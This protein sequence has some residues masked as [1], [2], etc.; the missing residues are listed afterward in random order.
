[1]YYF[2][3]YLSDFEVTLS[4]KGPNV[5]FRVKSSP[6]LLRGSEKKSL[7]FFFFVF[8]VSEQ[9]VLQEALF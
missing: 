6:N 2:E 5:Y 8:P 9:V 4:G 1:M 3:S 7:L